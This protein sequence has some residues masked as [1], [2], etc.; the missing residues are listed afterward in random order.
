MVQMQGWA[1]QGRPLGLWIGLDS[2]LA[3]GRE[4]E[5]VLSQ[6]DGGCLQEFSY[7]HLAS[8][9]SFI[10]VKLT[11]L[12]LKEYRV[13]EGSAERRDERYFLEW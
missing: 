11:W 12:R 8:K 10:R 9:G 4:N 1:S 7:R 13:E 5:S 2:L 6:E 3:P